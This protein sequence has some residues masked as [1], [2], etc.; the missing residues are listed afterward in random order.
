MLFNWNIFVLQRICK[1][2]FDQIYR[3]IFEKMSEINNTF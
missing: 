2:T 3:S 1:D